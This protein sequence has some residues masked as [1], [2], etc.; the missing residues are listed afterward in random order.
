[1]KTISKVLAMYVFK[2]QSNISTGTNIRAENRLIALSEK[3][4]FM[5]IEVFQTSERSAQTQTQL[6]L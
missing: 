3:V 1:M 5:I 2:P 6:L 4:Q